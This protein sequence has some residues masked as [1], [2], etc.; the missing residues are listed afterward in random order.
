[1][2]NATKTELEQMKSAA[3]Q[4]IQIIDESSIYSPWY[5]RNQ[6]NRDELVAFLVKIE[7]ELLYRYDN[8]RRAASAILQQRDPLRFA[9]RR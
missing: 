1:M 3:L 8:E 9:R 5:G 6:K 2:E 7:K 4:Q